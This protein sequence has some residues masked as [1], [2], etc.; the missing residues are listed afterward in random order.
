MQRRVK[1]HRGDLYVLFAFAERD[2]T[3]WALS[4]YDLRLEP[5]S[6]AQV[7]SNIGEPLLFCRAGR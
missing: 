2:R 5:E 6:C 7:T 3:E 1:S 4:G